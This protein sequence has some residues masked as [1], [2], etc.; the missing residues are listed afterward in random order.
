MSSKKQWRNDRGGVSQIG[1]DPHNP[2]KAARAR[3][4]FE[5]LF[6][7]APP[8]PSQPSPLLWQ[9]ESLAELKAAADRLKLFRE[10]YTGDFHTPGKDGE[11]VGAALLR[12]LDAFGRAQE[13][14]TAFKMEMAYAGKAFAFTAVPPEGKDNTGT[15]RMS[16][17]SHALIAPFLQEKA[18]AHGGTGTHP[19]S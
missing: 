18:K 14:L 11:G 2:E 16:P 6:N 12:R 9:A 4:A 15:I 10:E 7:D 3:K 5:A 17:A 1:Q 19:R 13:V 8:A